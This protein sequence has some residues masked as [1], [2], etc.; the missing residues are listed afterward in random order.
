MPKPKH[1]QPKAS[2]PPVRRKPQEELYTE[3]ERKFMRRVGRRI[4]GLRV[5][6]DLSQIQL[7]GKAK[8]SR[9]YLGFIEVGLRNPHLLALRKIA[10]A[11]GVPTMELLRIEESYGAAST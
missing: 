11:L 6:R 1:V 5:E 7:A 4:A 10:G 8:I 9:S 3:I 2:K